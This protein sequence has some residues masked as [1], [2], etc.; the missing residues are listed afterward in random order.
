MILALV[1]AR[2]MGHGF[3]S[4]LTQLGH[5][6]YVLQAL[7]RNPVQAFVQGEHTPPRWWAR[8]VPGFWLGTVED[9]IGTYLEHRIMTRVNAAQLH[10]TDPGP[11]GWGRRT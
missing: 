7:L 1:A 3:T 6:Q 11:F 5:V 10:R 2:L 8:A 9:L 4:Q